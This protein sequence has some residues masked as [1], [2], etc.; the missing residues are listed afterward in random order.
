MPAA[1]QLAADEG[2][3]LEAGALGAHINKRGF[4]EITIGEMDVCPD[5]RGE[6][7]VSKV[8]VFVGCFGELKSHG[9]V[10]EMPGAGEVHAD[11][12]G[13]RGSDHLRIADR[14]TRLN[15]RLHTGGQ[16]NLQ[17]IREGEKCVGGSNRAHGAI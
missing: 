4:G 11:P 5:V 14:T 10:E 2:A 7:Y 16:Q 13:F 6:I 12:G 15:D 1:V 17:A 9:S 8:L 3:P